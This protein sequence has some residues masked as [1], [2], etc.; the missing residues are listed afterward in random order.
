MRAD[1]KVGMKPTQ[2][3]EA[4]CTVISSGISALH[5]GG[6]QEMQEHTSTSRCAEWIT[7]KVMMLLAQVVSSKELRIVLL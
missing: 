4:V 3:L 5:T 2:R 1:L 7:G 6:R